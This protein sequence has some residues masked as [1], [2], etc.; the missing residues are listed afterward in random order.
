MDRFN[1]VSLVDSVS[2]L[3]GEA[4]D[5]VG[6]KLYI[7]AGA[8]Q[9][10]IQGFPGAAFVLVRKGFMERV[11]KYPKR[12]WY[13]NLAN[14]YEDQERGSIPFTPA[15]QVYYGFR[16]A[17]DELLE[18]G[19]QCRIQRF[20][21]YAKKIRETLESWGIKPF[22]SPEVRSNTLTAFQLPEGLTYTQLHDALKARGYVIYAGQGQL[23]SQIFRV[24]NIGALTDKN[25]E[26]F[27]AAFQDT[28][29]KTTGNG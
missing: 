18:E 29:K 26:G 5:I 23:E 13:L 25:I 2:G 4:L 10:C 12:S 11:M 6:S 22:L 21:G 20:E 7:V 9:K 27:L 24:G 16:E 1:K 19:V 15:V 28:L 14:Y 17:L 3:G 8:A